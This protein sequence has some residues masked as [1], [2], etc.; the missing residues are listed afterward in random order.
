MKKFF[1]PAA[2]VNAIA[3][4]SLILFVGIQIPAFSMWFYRWQFGLNDTYAVVNMYP[5]DL[6]E[7]T[8]HM[9]LY[10]QGRVPD[11]QIMTFVG[12]AARDFFSPIEIRHM[13]DVYY[14][15]HYGFMIQ[16]AMIALFVGSLGFFLW[17]GRAFVSYLFRAWQ[18]A[19][20]AT[21]GLL[22]V[23]VTAIAVNWHR[24]F[25]IFHEIFFDNDYWWLDPRE[26]LL[27]NIVPYDFFI[28]CSVFIG[29]FFVGG[30]VLLFLGSTLLL[31]RKK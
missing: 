20:S 5:Q 31:R 7:V 25:I 13:V 21:F 9:I 15:F 27:I 17:R 22:A 30:L 3:L 4:V 29:A 28:A 10:M 19:A 14:L 6:H 8:R 12:G 18:I 26:D 2:V 16:Y 24:A 11:L 1:I 23:L